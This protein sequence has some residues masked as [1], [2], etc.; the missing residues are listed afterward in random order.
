MKKTIFVL[1]ILALIPRCPTIPFGPVACT[2][3]PNTG[4]RSV[5]Y[6]THISIYLYDNY[7]NYYDLARLFSHVSILGGAGKPSIS[8]ILP[9]TKDISTTSLLRDINSSYD[10]ISLYA[11]ETDY[12]ADYYQSIFGKAPTDVEIDQLEY[13]K[14]LNRSIGVVFP[15]PN[16]VMS[17][18]EIDSFEANISKAPTPHSVYLYK[19]DWFV[20]ET[21]EGWIYYQNISANDTGGYYGLKIYNDSIQPFIL[22]SNFTEYKDGSYTVPARHYEELGDLDPPSLT[23]WPINYYGSWAV[24]K[25]Q[26]NGSLTIVSLPGIKREF[27]VPEGLYILNITAERTSSGSFHVFVLDTNNFVRAYT[28]ENITSNVTLTVP[29]PEPGTWKIIVLSQETPVNFSVTI[30]LIS[31][32][33]LDDFASY[34]NGIVLA[35]RLNAIAIPYA[36]EPIDTEGLRRVYIVDF[37]GTIPSNL[38]S[39]LSEKGIEVVRISSLSEIVDMLFGLGQY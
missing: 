8:I 12:D 25:T 28:N 30:E 33:D 6:R 15:I 24:L 18:T 36:G 29:Y 37:N 17:R 13:P 14:I 32:R 7:S 26:Q 1:L 10:T 20:M 34:L 31:M 27:S 3:R 16:M 11:V 5:S 23:I 21:G 39:E 35:Q 19:N 4:I 2:G 9:P 38:D 22:Y